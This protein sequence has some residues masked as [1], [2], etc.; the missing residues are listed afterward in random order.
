MF[1]TIRK[2]IKIELKRKSLRK[3]NVF[4]EEK[5]K[6]RKATFKGNN[7]IAK[8]VDFENSYL[9]RGSCINHDCQLAHVKIKNFSCIGP[10]ANIAIGNHPTK[11][12][13]TTHSFAYSHSS[14]SIGLGFLDD[15]TFDI[16]A[17]V[18]GSKYYLEIGNDVWVGKNVT[19]LSGITIGDGSIIAAGAVV[20]KSVEPYSIVGG[21]PA[22][23]IRKRFNENDIN[24]LLEFKWWDKPLEWIKD[25]VKL[26]SDIKEFKKKY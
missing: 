12:Y 17:N 25:N 22:K 23:I 19:F 21:V 15:V 3:N 6:F 10:G 26:F 7:A 8:N 5:C 1:N 24:Y 16:G 11:D 13:V 2:K 4:I 14:K 18:P 9:G 20:T